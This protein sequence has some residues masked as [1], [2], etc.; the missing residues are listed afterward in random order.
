[1]DLGKFWLPVPDEDAWALAAV[2][3]KG[4]ALVAK[5][6]RAPDGV[7]T[8][9]EVKESDLD[10]SRAVTGDVTAP[11]DLIDLPS[12]STAAVL[13]TLRE[14]HASDQIY[15]A[16]GPVILALNPFRPTQESA[17]EKIASLLFTPPDEL[18]PH[19][20]NVARS[21][22]SVMCAGC[23]LSN[24]ALQPQASLCLCLC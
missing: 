12:I 5:R 11:A 17:P 22:Y 13:H 4:G 14:R 18:P 15:T 16:V 19:V 23:A 20:F 10:P 24:P 2:T 9:F 3:K 8:E 1:M 7:P 21:A 6:L